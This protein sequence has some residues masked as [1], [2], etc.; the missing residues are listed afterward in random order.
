MNKFLTLIRR[1]MADNRGALVITPIVIAAILLTVTLFATLTG[2]AR[3]GFD[4]EDF[5]AAKQHRGEHGQMIIDAENGPA[6]VKRGLDGKITITSPDGETKTLDQAIDPK[7]KAGLEAIL[8]V[9]TAAAAVLPLAI[10]L[11]S[12]LFVLAGALHD[13]RKDRTILFW[14]S[15]PVSDLQTTSAKLVSIVGVGLFFALAVTI[16]LHVA[17]TGLAV[18]TL[19]NVGI[20]G[21]SAAT[22]FLN[23][24]KLWSVLAVGLLIYVGWAL[25]VYGWVTMVSAWA[26]KMPFVAAFAPLFVVPLVYMAIAYRGD[27]NDT[28]LNALWEPAGRLIGEPMTNGMSRIIEPSNDHIPAIPVTEMLGQLSNSLAQPGFWIGLAVAGGF[29]Y[30]ASEIRRRRAL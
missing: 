19:G 8:P 2:N 24:I 4:P 18:A 15:M 13:E 20:T 1:D 3:F 16:V 25:P 12:I 21:I 7:T 27:D 10:A 6:T 11:I 22:V 5:A 29:I 30:A 26:P 17:I 28:I 23:A 9:G 14:K